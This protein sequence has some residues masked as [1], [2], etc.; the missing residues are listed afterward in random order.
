ME[1]IGLSLQHRKSLQEAL[2]DFQEYIRSEAFAKELRE[3]EERKEFFQQELPKRLPLLS[4][5]D[6]EE[7]VGLLW[8][9]RMWGNKSYVAQKLVEENGLESIRR[10][11]QMLYSVEPPEKA[12]DEFLSLVKGWGPASVTEMLAYIYPQRCGIWNKQA[13][14]GLKALGLRELVNVEKYQLS[15][16]EYKSFN[17]LLSAIGQELQ[18]VMQDVDLLIVDFFLY[19]L[20]QRQRPK[21]EME[22]FDH[23]EV[24]DLIY[25]IGVNLGFDA[26]TEV[27]LARGARVDVVWR[28]R[29]A[30]LGAVAYVFEVHRSGSIDSLI[31]NLQKA[32]GVP[33]VQKVIAVSDAKQLRQIEKECEGLPEQLR[34]ALRLWDVSDV[35]Q[36]A[37]ALQQV[38]SSVGKLGLLEEMR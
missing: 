32:L 9:H 28:A 3:R 16:K 27:S 4:E 38:M 12:Y 33:S 10:G 2:R 1:E 36:T 17:Q 18:A 35:F 7:I 37:D 24:R 13:R 22:G 30:N 8:A 29:I 34:R 19:H 25:Q 5:A 14:D 26:Q 6:V 23:D 31:L 11:L 20:A 21:I 15:P